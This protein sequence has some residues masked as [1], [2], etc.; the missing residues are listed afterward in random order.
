[1]GHTHGLAPSSS[2]YRQGSRPAY[3]YG[4]CLIQLRPLPG[5]STSR[6]GGMRDMCIYSIPRRYSV[7]QT[8]RLSSPVQD[9]SPLFGAFFCV[10]Y[11]S[12]I[13][14]RMLHICLGDGGPVS[15]TALRRS[16]SYYVPL[17]VW[18]RSC[19]GPF[20]LV[21]FPCLVEPQV[22]QEYA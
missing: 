6:S 10:C 7:P 8:A 11:T 19:T 5:Y 22:E 20:F 17:R 12:D 16:P 2:Q 21:R 1:M 14:N 15:I 4:S 13:T 9:L 18:G 3:G